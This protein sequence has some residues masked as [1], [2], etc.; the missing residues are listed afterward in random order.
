MPKVVDHESRRRE[1]SEAVWRVVA[2]RGLDGATVKD[3]ADEAGVSTG[4]LA[5]YFEGKDALLVHALRTSIG[6][7][8]GRV[9]RRDEAVS[10]MESLRGVLREYMP[11]DNERRDM[12]AVWLSFWGRAVH[13]ES[14][15]DEQRRWY[16]KWR[17]VIESLV[18]EAQREGG[19]AGSLDAGRES[20]R[21]VALVDG[22][23]IQATFEPERLTPEAQTKLLDEQLDGL[24]S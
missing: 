11:L 15:A 3:I 7:T 12:W 1:I 5:H 23:G 9:E 13:D 18:R 6:E 20:D 16:G 10:G 8:A 21:L 19:V 22:I 2:R 24:K 17:G 4:V 14:L